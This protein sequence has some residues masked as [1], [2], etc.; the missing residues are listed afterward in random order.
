MPMAAK[1]A[2]KVALFLYV[3]RDIPLK[4][5]SGLIIKPIDTRKMPTQ[6]SVVGGNPRMI[7]EKAIIRTGNALAIG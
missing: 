3:A 7:S 1:I 5:S 6:P 2:H 4:E